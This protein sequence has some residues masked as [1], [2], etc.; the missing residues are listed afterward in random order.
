MRGTGV[1]VTGPVPVISTT[2]TVSRQ[3]PSKCTPSAGWIAKEPA[4]SGSARAGAARLRPEG[5]GALQHGDVPILVVEVRGGLHARREA[6]AQHVEPRSARVPGPRRRGRR[7]PSSGTPPGPA[8]G[9]RSPGSPSNPPRRSRGRRAG[10]PRA[11][12]RR[13][14]GVGGRGG[15]HG[16]A[17]RNAPFPGSRNG[18]RTPEPPVARQGPA[19]GT[20]PV[21]P[22]SRTVPAGALPGATSLATAGLRRRLRLWCR[23]P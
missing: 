6:H 20:D 11:R 8:C 5:P 14:D 3:A 1:V 2:V 22:P 21:A 4:G 7:C 18:L 17:W 16:A 15:E 10:P 12:P 23:R 9:S 13:L 19:P